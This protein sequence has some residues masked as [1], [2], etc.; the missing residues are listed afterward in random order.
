MELH[1]NQ[2]A[3]EAPEPHHAAYE[4]PDY[5]PFAD[6]LNNLSRVSDD[7]STRLNR[8]QDDQLKADL[9][10]AEDRANKL[11]DD[12]ASADAD[13][14]SLSEKAL[15]EVQAAFYQYD[16]PARIRFNRANKT[17]FDELQLAVTDK[18]LKKKA[19]QLIN[20]VELNIPLWA[21]QAVAEGTW[22]ARKRGI[23]KIQSSLKG[24]ASPEQIAKLEYT[25]NNS[26]DKANLNNLITAGTDEALAEAKTYMTNPK[27]AASLDPYERSVFLG[28]IKA[29][30]KENAKAKAKA[31]DPLSLS[32]IQE[33]A[34][35]S[36]AGDTATAQII[37]K[38]VR[39]GGLV[40]VL[41]ADEEGNIVKSYV[42]TSKMSESQRLGMI[43][44]MKKYDNLNPDFEKDKASYSAELSEALTLYQKAVDDDDSGQ[45]EMLQNLM[46]LSNNG[47]F[48]H[49][50]N[51]TQEKVMGAINEQ[52]KA[53]V[54]ASLGEDQQYTVNAT[55]GIVPSVGV[56]MLGKITSG[57]PFGYNK[58]VGNP[59]TMLRESFAA[60]NV[61]AG[62]DS[63]MGGLMAS[64]LREQ[65]NQKDVSP[66]TIQ[67]ASKAA[68]VGRAI[69]P[70]STTPYKNNITAEM[71]GAANI[72]KSR[73]GKDM[74]RNSVAELG[75]YN[76]ILLP[77]LRDNNLL[78]GTRFE[79]TNLSYEKAYAEW[80]AGLKRQGLYNA[81]VSKDN[82]K[83]IYD[84]YEILV[85]D[86]LTQAEKD[87]VQTTLEYTKSGQA[88]EDW[89]KAS[90]YLFTPE[91]PRTFGYSDAKTK[92]NYELMKTMTAIK[93]S[94]RV[95]KALKKS[96]L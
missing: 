76:K 34:R 19:S 87:R 82:E 4:K 51:G 77:A 27:K 43:S 42:D 13:Y 62:R 9:K 72:W 3:W 8:M 52:L 53:R 31:E 68:S 44:E 12:A 10:L 46:S 96:N 1:K 88:N 36:A 78:A 20:E 75:L 26:I 39:T 89:N 86:E 55:G 45:D 83:R 41:T 40:P 59:V 84:F 56:A 61:S 64:L 30:E 23:N 95:E 90:A 79:K 47:L 73:F 7:I 25:Y 22:D 70:E 94:D 49:M 69:M 32:V 57:A 67:E 24:Y 80:S 50:E 35:N 15:S 16:E 5:Q 28:R 18:I 91:A 71:M 14:D 63:N 92:P 66:Y 17:Y 37:F 81:R 33:Y 2:I 60:P 74:E 48:D 85:G 93:S 58:K 21:S 38:T 65:G 11:I 6:A 29:Q 54:E